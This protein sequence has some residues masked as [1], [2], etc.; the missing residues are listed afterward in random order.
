MS[1]AK[2]LYQYWEENNLPVK[3]H[4][5]TEYL[6]NA[7]KYGTSSHTIPLQKTFP[8]YFVEPWTVCFSM[9]HELAYID[10]FKTL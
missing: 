5:G 9:N 6:F 8:E 4:D 10:K 1:T 3:I 7:Y 2:T